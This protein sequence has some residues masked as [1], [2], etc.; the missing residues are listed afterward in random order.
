LVV[1]FVC[2]PDS[3]ALFIVQVAGTSLP[4]NF[5]SLCHLSTDVAGHIQ[6]E[7][8]GDGFW[9]EDWRCDSDGCRSS[10]GQWDDRRLNNN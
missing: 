8:D 1:V 2:D 5:V 7:D 4:R 10:S 9:L 3:R 6:V